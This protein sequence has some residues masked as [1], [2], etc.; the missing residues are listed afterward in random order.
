MSEAMHSTIYLKDYSPS[1]FLIDTVDLDVD[2]HH[3]HTVVRSRLTI[4]R[5]PSATQSSAALALDGEDLMLDSIAIDGRSLEPGA[6]TL[7][8]QSLTIPNVPEA[9]VLETVCRIRPQDNTK[10]SGFY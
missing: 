7:T 5:N 9:F 10:L 4:R 1:A 6:Y 8:P 2:I 3:E